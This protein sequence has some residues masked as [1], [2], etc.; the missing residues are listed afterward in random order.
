MKEEITRL[1][2]LVNDFLAVGRQTPPNVAPCDVREIIGQAI[3]LVEK[4]AKQQ[5]IQIAYNLPSDLPTLQADAAQLKTCF[6]NILTNSVQAMP[7]GGSIHIEAKQ[8]P[9]S[10]GNMRLRLLFR[11]TG[12]GIP[13]EDREK[14]FTPY[15]ST[16]VTG[17]GLGLG[18][19]QG[20]RRQVRGGEDGRP[21]CNK[22]WAVLANLPVGE[23]EALRLVLWDG[24]SHAEAAQVLGCSPTAARI[25][26]PRASRRLAQSV[27]AVAAA[28]VR[29]SKRR[30]PFGHTGSRSAAV[31]Y[32]AEEA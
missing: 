2:R 32:D 18:E 29:R 11:D 12:P 4:Q 13:L 22:L 8:L 5:D 28:A 17:F 26:L 15:F 20:R 7:N 21:A 27:A 6:L 10:K 23:A 1:N 19:G 25:R 31:C 3:S 14:I 24:L 9:G 30:G 16:K